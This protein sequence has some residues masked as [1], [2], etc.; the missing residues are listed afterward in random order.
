M[1]VTLTCRYCGYF[2][3]DYFSK[4]EDVKRVRHCGRCGDPNVKIQESAKLTIDT[5]GGAPPFEEP[6]VPLSDDND[7]EDWGH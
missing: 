5:Y 2:W 6:A 3:E 7:Y 1:R 4:Q